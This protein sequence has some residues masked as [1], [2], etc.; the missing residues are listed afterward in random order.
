M[1]RGQKGT[2]SARSMTACCLRYFFLSVLQS[3]ERVTISL[4]VPF[5]D[6]LRHW[7]M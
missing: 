6:S 2:S 7:S 1:S 4:W 3:L 5:S